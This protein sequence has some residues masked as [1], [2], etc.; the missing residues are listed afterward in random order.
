MFPLGNRCASIN[1]GTL[2][3]IDAGIPMK[4]FVCA[5][6]ATF[7]EDTP[8]LGEPGVY[9]CGCGWGGVSV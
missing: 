3:L 9:V 2:A 7:L 1:A 4:D 8:L 5:C 6:S